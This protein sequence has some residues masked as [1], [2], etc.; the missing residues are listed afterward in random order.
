MKR[1]VALIGAATAIG[2]GVVAVRRRRATFRRAGGE[3]AT[4][5]CAVE[6][7]RAHR[8]HV[9]HL[10]IAPVVW[11][12]ALAAWP[13][14]PI[15][16]A[17]GAAIDQLRD[18]VKR[19]LDVLWR[20][21]YDY[22]I[23]LLMQVVDLGI[24][25][26]GFVLDTAKRFAGVAW[27]AAQKFIDLTLQIVRMGLAVLEA[28]KNFAED[29]FDVA[30]G[31]IY[32][33]L[34]AAGRAIEE[35]KQWVQDHIGAP[36]YGLILDVMRWVDDHVLHP[37]ERLIGDVVGAVWAAINTAVGMIDDVYDFIVHVLHPW[38]QA[39]E[40]VLMW[41]MRIAM[42]PTHATDDLAEWIATWSIPLFRRIVLD[43]VA[44]NEEMIEDMVMR[45][46]D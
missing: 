22:F 27:D 3:H 21:F 46:L 8:L 6:S 29:L 31:L 24:A 45:W 42:D 23:A 18:W 37:L 35:A 7:P 36:L 14:D 25:F 1:R 9:V 5:R 30:R 10:L 17:G 26:V 34:V 11:V 12:I 19:A 41:V 28:A 39:C 44:E 43:T 38:W 32:D 2:C 15:I 20:A 16:D 40:W 33:V 13:W 4:A